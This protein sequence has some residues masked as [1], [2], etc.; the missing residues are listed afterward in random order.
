MRKNLG[1]TLIEL[2]TVVAIV[3]V[4]MLVAIPSF[5]DSIARRRLEGIA[6]ELNAD[7]QYAR[8]QAISN[9]ASVSLVATSTGY[10]IGTYKTITLI[11]NC[12]LAAVSPSTLPL[13]ITFEAN[14]GT[15]NADSS[16][17]LSCSQTTATLQ[18]V[19]S[20]LGRVQL[21]SPSGSFGGY[22]TC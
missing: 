10:V 1:V 15:A 22:T 12:T 16:L 17:L 18:V 20:S 11:S 19:T 9:N 14:R 5:N 8:T 4:L 21:C 7:L 3:A 13:T 2:L 6:N